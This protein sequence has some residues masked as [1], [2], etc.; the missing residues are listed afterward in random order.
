MAADPPLHCP[1]DEARALVGIADV[2]AGRKL[3]D[4]VLG[5]VMGDTAGGSRGIPGMTIDSRC[6]LP[7]CPRRRAAWGP[8]RMTVTPAWPGG[9]VVTADSPVQVE[10]GGGGG[11][12][13]GRAGGTA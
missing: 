6:F 2:I 8:G 11:P 4:A 10:C 13:G 12:P 1:S 3:V 7:L 5:V 9:V